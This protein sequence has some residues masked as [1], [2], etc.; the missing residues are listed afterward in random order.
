M[1]L[2]GETLPLQALRQQVSSSPCYLIHLPLQALR[3]QVS[4]SPRYLKDTLDFLTLIKIEPT[5]SAVQHLS[6]KTFKQENN[7]PPFL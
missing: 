3:Q 7:F 5:C 4:F 2:W 6:F 1:S